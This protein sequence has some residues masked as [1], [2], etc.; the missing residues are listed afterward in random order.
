MDEMMTKYQSVE[1]A[2][3]LPEDEQARI[4]AGLRRLGKTSAKDLTEDER[5]SLL[6]S[7]E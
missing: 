3:I 5:K 1:H 2:E 7:S 4:N 6:N